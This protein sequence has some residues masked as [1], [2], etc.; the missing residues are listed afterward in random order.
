MTAVANRAPMTNK[1]LERLQWQLLAMEKD[2]YYYCHPSVPGLT[3]SCN[4]E[5]GVSEL[6]H[7][8]VYSSGMYIYATILLRPPLHVE[9]PLPLTLHQH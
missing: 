2:H 6:T 4:D 1:S 7:A 8:S 5:N 3:C 9:L